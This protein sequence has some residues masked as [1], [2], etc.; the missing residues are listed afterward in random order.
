M[1]RKYAYL[2]LIAA[3]AVLVVVGALLTPSPVVAQQP[4]V[5]GGE[6]EVP[7]EQGGDHTGIVVGATVAAILIGIFVATKLK[8]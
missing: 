3:L 2:G 6:V 7:P 1:R 4:Y 8:E 5:V